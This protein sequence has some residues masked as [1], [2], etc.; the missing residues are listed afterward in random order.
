MKTQFFYIYEINMS[1]FKF[2]ILIGLLF[3]M[4]EANSNEIKDSPLVIKGEQEALELTD[5]PL[6]PYTYDDLTYFSGH[7][8]PEKDVL[9]LLNEPK[10]L[11][12]FD[13]DSVAL[14][15]YDNDNEER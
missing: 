11:L 1:T 14:D 2:A 12:N 5:L 9:S 6:S 3:L 8:E 7:F 15:F 13:K 10:L 4:G